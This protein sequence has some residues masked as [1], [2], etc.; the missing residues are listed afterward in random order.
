MEG[1]GSSCASG[2]GESRGRAIDVVAICC[3]VKRSLPSQPSVP[4][5]TDIH[6]CGVCLEQSRAVCMIP[7]TRCLALLGATPSSSSGSGAGSF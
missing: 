7:A 6:A 5:P 2:M 1:E 4:S 3:I